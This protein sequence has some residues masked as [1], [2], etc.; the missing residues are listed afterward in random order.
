MAKLHMLVCLKVVPKPEEIRVDEETNR[1]ERA[2]VRSELNPPDMNAME[3]A[4]R[5]KDRYGGRISILTMGPPYFEPYLR[6]GLAMGADHIY[7]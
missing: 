7:L 1:L 6:V 3:M 4:L 5:L 2:D